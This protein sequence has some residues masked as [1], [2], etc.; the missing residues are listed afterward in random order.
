MAR[1]DGRELLEVLH[2]R[3]VYCLHG[4]PPFRC[5]ALP[6]VLGFLLN[7]DLPDGIRED[8]HELRCVP[9]RLRWCS[10]A[11]FRD[12][13]VIDVRF[14]AILY[15]CEFKGVSQFKGVKGYF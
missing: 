5:I 4:Y 9:A 12:E 8:G 7:A 1:K 13:W 15:N 3:I 10:V 14:Q 11:S 2:F 6:Y